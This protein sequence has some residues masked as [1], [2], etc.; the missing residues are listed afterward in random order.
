MATLKTCL[1]VVKDFTKD[2]YERLEERA[3]ELAGG[4]PLTNTHFV[5]AAKDLIA[6]REGWIEQIDAAVAKETP[7][8]EP[9]P[10]P[11][12]EAK[13]EPEPAKAEPAANT[14]L[15]ANTPESL[16]E[17]KAALTRRLEK[18][19]TRK[20]VTLA[21][22]DENRIEAALA[23][24]DYEL[25]KSIISEVETAMRERRYRARD[26][27]PAPKTPID[28]AELEQI[29][30]EVEKALGGK[31]DVTILD[32]ETELDP[33]AEPGK[34]AGALI[35]GKVY[36]FRDGIPSGAEGLKTTFHELLHKGLRNLLPEADY[37]ALMLK[38]YNNS[39]AVQKLAD[40]W[41]NSKSGR[42]TVED[43]I[44]AKFA[45]AALRD[46]SFIIAAD[47]ALA[48]MAESTTL[49]PGTLRQIG[50]W[51]AD[52]A[53]KLGMKRLAQMVRSMGI[54]PLQKFVQDALR[55]SV[56]GT[57]QSAGNRFRPGTP[58]FERWFGKSKVVDKNGQPLVVHHSTDADFT[59]F[60]AGEGSAGFFFSDDADYSSEWG[61]KKM[62]LYLRMEAPLDLRDGLSAAAAAALSKAGVDPKLIRSLKQ[63]Y[64]HDPFD[65]DDG[66]RYVSE[67]KKAGYDGL[68][69]NNDAGGGKT[70]MV[71]EPTQIKS[72]TGNNGK[73]DP[74][75]P[76]IRY[77]S[78]EE[79]VQRM[80]DVLKFDVLGKAR[81]GVLSASFLRDLRDR[82]AGK[83]KG[84]DE[85]TK[86]T[87]DMSAAAAEIQE[88]GTKVYDALSALS[89]TEKSA[90]VDLMADA[91]TKQVHVEGD[92]THLGEVG[93]PLVDEL[94]ARF[95]K[96]NEKQKRAYRLARDTLA[97]NWK[98]RGELLAVKVDETYAP[99]IE[100]A[101][102]AGDEKKV[103]TLERERRDYLVDTNKALSQIKGDYF[104]LMRFGEFMVVRKSEAYETLAAEVQKAHAALDALY[105][106][107]ERRTPEER[108][109]ISKANK[110][111]KKS[112]AEFDPEFTPEQAAEIKAA[113]DEYT[114]LQNE[115]EAMKSS[116]TD[117]YMAQFE[118]RS[119]AEADA[120]A[121][122]GTVLLKQDRPR[123][124]NPISRAVLDR[125]A[126]SI[127]SSLRAQGNVAALREAK[128]ALY[129][130]FLTSLPERSALMRQ[131]KR[132][133]V[134][135]FSRDMERS[136]ISSILRDSF[137]LSRMEHAD[138]VTEA[139]NTAWKDA[140][141]QKNPDLQQVA[142]EL[143]RRLVVSMRYTD[144]PIQDAITGLTYAWMLGV[145]PGYLV[146]NLMQPFM[147]SMPMLW[148][149]HGLK[150]NATFGKAL[151]DTGK[152]MSKHA[153]SIL[154]G[155]LN[156]E[157]S[158]LPEG[159]A[160]MLQELL[161]ERLLSVTLV[162]DLARTAD[163]KAVSRF[164]SLLARPA[165]VVEMANR[166]ATALAAYR[167]EKGKSGDAAAQR[168]AAKVLADTHF[169]YSAENAPY[170]MKPGALAGNKLLFQF[171]KY[172]AG[173][174]SLLVKTLA[175]AAKG[176]KVAKAE[177][178]RVLLGV[179]GTHF[180]V[181]GAIGL[182][183]FGTLAMLAN[184]IA[185]AFGDDEPW[186]A[187]V[188]MRNYLHDTFGPKVGNALSKGLPTLL[189]AVGLGAD[190]SKKAGLGD[191]L[192][193]VPTLRDDK[194]GR[195]FYL[196]LLASGMGPF[197]G[198][199]APRAFD[200]ASN[201]ANG[202]FLK[203]A[204][205]L[206]PK[207]MADPLRAGRFATEGV[208][209]KQGTVALPR[210][211]LGF[212]DLFLQA[213]G[214]PA[215]K[216]TDSYEARAAVEEVKSTLNER[217][218][219]LK[220]RWVDARKDGDYAQA[221]ELWDEI[222]DKVN[223]VRTKNGLKPVTL[224]ELY[225][226]QRQRDKTEKKYRDFGANTN[227]QMGE[228]ARFAR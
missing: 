140:E 148:S 85:Y 71:F 118:S 89:A 16:S 158:G 162:G 55:A 134:A 214:I 138:R 6:S 156:L 212:G 78:A 217:V 143:Q 216:I 113:R 181:G 10:A 94:K 170:W 123:E 117:Y 127:D 167:L 11:A 65:F 38:L 159:E 203:A 176:D 122:G 5:R 121:N 215:L 15:T 178:R 225:Q 36:L 66:A 28:R 32:S 108:K 205:G 29:V 152:L 112:G 186:D 198:G 130:V 119:E 30:S 120:R 50:N 165:H 197:F 52:V 12:P 210:D 192:N 142:A 149:R 145:S 111:L 177:A 222:R 93:Q 174:I 88:A 98:K 168:Y 194:K 150:S 46:E 13:A 207:W 195:D 193:P 154:R 110:E 51:L 99:L 25:A 63:G 59:Q 9:E 208:T 1:A 4:K 42:G 23:K 73:Y 128:Q 166:I 47:E 74:T 106:K 39:A 126:E 31:A 221:Q 183:A 115:L 67:L 95:E 86:A 169:D 171:K 188:A 204:E 228:L 187:E 124:L 76:D 14:D 146:A 87:F 218:G 213:I 3:T 21:I 109:A 219:R 190:M 206:L 153:G 80:G 139:L 200:A 17:E 90:V 83:I 220:D 40:E 62:D 151:V 27:A 101:R 135:G 161:R 77:R 180:A 68:V 160:A 19:R 81:R 157:D 114:K 102:N 131:A 49:T 34:N 179:L 75:N 141:A 48:K 132:K 61:D 92:N 173:M 163:G 8:P 155:E 35:G 199:I 64:T 116:E 53:D 43:L 84:V 107:Y 44:K 69:F 100:A 60:K 227:A 79:A 172:Q 185:S 133:T 182:P 7:K 20:D 33:K 202:N 137:Y 129:Q 223:P 2:D 54:S 184:A 105:D 191:V 136:V 196:E 41:L 26:D 57:P 56:Q 18:L 226:F 104:P 58:A 224:S 24:G 175:N 164:S 96:L 70:F 22:D 91:T 82:F 189:G 209:T 37:R 201:L 144:T 147:V 97:G 45:G 103:R 72:A 125:M 211:Q